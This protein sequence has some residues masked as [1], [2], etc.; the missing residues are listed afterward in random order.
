MTS[1]KNINPFSKTNTNTGFGTNVGDYGGRFINKDGTFN[2]RKEGLPFWKTT[3]LY[4]NLLNLPAWKFVV[5][6]LLAYLSINVVFTMIYILIGVNQLQGILAKE[7]WGKIREVFYFSAET[8]TTVGYGRVNPIGDAANIVSSF[9]SMSGFL[10]FAVVTGLM[11]GRFTRPRGYMVFSEHAVIAPYQDKTALMLRLAPYKAHHHITDADI[12]LN[13]GFIVDEKGEQV[14]K[15]FE[16]PL[17]RSHV[18]SL[19]MNWTVVHPIDENS[20][21]LGFTEHDLASSDTEVYVLVRGFDDVFS[22]TV[23]QRTSYT[24]KEIIYGAKFVPM[25]RESDD[26]KTTILELD[27]LNMYEKVFSSL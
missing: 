9:E 18:D 14:Y 26:G 16:L 1:F 23:I 10:S 20:P 13:V 5:Y 2:L 7:Y 27:K 21:L 12:R 4:Y 11:Y 6:L 8:F 17:E 25:Y 19:T 15:F 3:S 22:N 24:Y